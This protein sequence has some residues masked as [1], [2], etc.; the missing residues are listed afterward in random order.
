MQESRRII[1][2]KCKYC[3]KVFTRR[4]L[5]HHV[6]KCHHQDQQERRHIKERRTESKKTENEEDKRF[7]CSCNDRFE[8]KMHLERHILRDSC[9]ATI[10]GCSVRS[11]NVQFFFLSAF[12]TPFSSIQACDYRTLYFRDLLLHSEKH[13]QNN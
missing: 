1:R 13:K 3:D 10:Y 5:R 4:R 6:R 2:K 8:T 7:K 12:Q 11:S 9:G